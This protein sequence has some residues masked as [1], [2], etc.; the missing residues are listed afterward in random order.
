M[1]ICWH[2]IHL[3]GELEI[4]AIRQQWGRNPLQRIDQVASGVCSAFRFVAR[5]LLEVYGAP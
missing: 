2:V 3:R 1:V 5:N 4:D